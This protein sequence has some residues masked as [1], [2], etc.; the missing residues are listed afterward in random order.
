MG[1]VVVPNYLHHV[2]QRGYIRQAVFAEP[3][4]FAYCLETLAEFRA[5]Y[6]VQ[7]HASCLMT[8][9]V[10]LALQPGERVAGLW[11]SG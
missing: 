2:V 6:V 1:Q 8:N 9:H 11:A 4:D 7:V 10:Q 5:E 3:A